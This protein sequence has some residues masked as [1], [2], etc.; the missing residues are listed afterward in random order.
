MTET[1]KGYTS[2]NIIIDM[3]VVCPRFH[4]DE[5]TVPCFI[6][7]FIGSMHTLANAN[8]RTIALLG[9]TIAVHKDR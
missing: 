3:Q 4:C 2:N 8:R 1:R 6:S 5:S 9:M 7:A